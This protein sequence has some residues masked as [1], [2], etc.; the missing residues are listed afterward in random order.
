MNLNI[1]YYALLGVPN[2]ADEKI[3]KKSYYKLSFIHHPD[4][5]GEDKDGDTFG[6]I[7]EAYNILSDEKLKKDYDKKSKWGLNY[8]EIIELLNYDFGDYSKIDSDSAYQDFKSRE[9]L[10]IIIKIDDTFNGTVK[11]ERYVTCKTCK[12]SGKDTKSKIEIKDAKGNVIK[13]FDSD[14]GCDFC[15]GSGKGYN[16]LD[17]GFCYGQGKVGMKEC[18]DCKGQKRILG[19]QKLS[20]I[21]FPK[22]AKDHK[23]EFMGHVAKD[24]PG[25]VGHLWLVRV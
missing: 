7:S 12:G 21:D 16:G 13:T 4:K 24:N 6:R 2:S 20:K 15:E 14:D 5:N 23:V 19:K 11:Y 18:S 17:C 25:M 9:Q 1:N 8:N 10:T 22:D 3:I